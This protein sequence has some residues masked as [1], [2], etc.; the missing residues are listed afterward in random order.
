LLKKKGR[1]KEVPKTKG[2]EICLKQTLINYEKNL[3]GPRFLK[4][5]QKHKGNFSGRVVELVYIQS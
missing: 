4:S 5:T 1:E 3:L 2:S